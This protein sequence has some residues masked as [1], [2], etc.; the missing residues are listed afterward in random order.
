MGTALPER[1]RIV[2]TEIHENAAVL[3]RALHAVL[4]LRGQRIAGAPGREWFNTNPVEI[5]SLIA[6]VMG[7]AAADAAADADTGRADEAAMQNGIDA[8]TGAEAALGEP[9]DEAVLRPT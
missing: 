6:F 1:P 8:E 7:A 3:E 2:L 4:E 5:R 9:A